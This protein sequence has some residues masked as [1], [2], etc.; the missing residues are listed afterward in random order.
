MKQLLSPQK[1]RQLFAFS[2]VLLLIGCS[3]AL[4]E[5]THLSLWHEDILKKIDACLPNDG[6]LIDPP[7][8]K[9]ISITHEHA[10]FSQIN[11]VLDHYPTGKGYLGISPENENT[12]QYQLRLDPNGQVLG[13][14]RNDLN[15]KAWDHYPDSAFLSEEGDLRQAA[16]KSV[17]TYLKS[18]PML[19]PDSLT[20][21]KIVVNEHDNAYRFNSITEDHP[22]WGA[23]DHTVSV[24]IEYPID[25]LAFQSGQTVTMVW[26]PLC[27][28]LIA[29]HA[30]EQ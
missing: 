20:I 7:P 5:E 1:R 28:D 15:L 16:L 10:L 4:A 30:G 9:N 25:T 17:E 12:L 13:V 26:S 24:T 11:I 22:L 18:L 19:S 27:D 6:V 3:A 8:I 2:A 14:V 23:T 29:W 21:K